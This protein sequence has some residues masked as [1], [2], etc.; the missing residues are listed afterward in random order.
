MSQYWFPYGFLLTLPLEIWLSLFAPTLAS[1]RCA[2]WVANIL[3]LIVIYAALIKFVRSDALRVVGACFLW[4]IPL[5]AFSLTIPMAARYGVGF[6][7]LLFWPRKPIAAGAM[8]VIALCTSQ[9]I[10]AAVFV[11]SVVVFW[12]VTDRHALRRYFAGF[13]G[14]AV[15]SAVYI[16]VRY[17]LQNYMQATLFDVGTTLIH[18]KLPPQL[19]DVGAIRAMWHERVSVVMGMQRLADGIALYTPLLFNFLVALYIL[20]KRKETDAAF[21]GLFVFALILLLPAW[22]RTDRWHIFYSLT[23][24]VF[25]WIVF[26]DQQT[27]RRSR[28]APALTLI[29]LLVGSFITLPQ[30]FSKRQKRQW[31]DDSLAPVKVERGGISRIPFRQKFA[32]ELLTEWLNTHTRPEEKFVF[33]PYDGAL[34]FFSGKALPCRHPLLVTAAYTNQ[35]SATVQELENEKVMWV[36]WDS[37]NT[38]FDGVPVDKFLDEVTV[39]LKTNFVPVDEMGPFIFLQRRAAGGTPTAEPARG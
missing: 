20:K 13:A 35:Q 18:N 24:S 14:A 36:I 32:Y 27:N 25:L 16:S 5:A 12:R 10:G 11:A 30:Y 23:P 29:F 7:P 26:I 8:T 37:Q 15:V 4:M 31:L 19:I 9:E 21:L 28:S 22:G 33:Y 39:Y 6:L 34:Y 2:A 17:G 3:G 38:V 1:V